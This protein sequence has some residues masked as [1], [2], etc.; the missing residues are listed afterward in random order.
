MDARSA[1]E[2]SSEAAARAIC[3]NSLRRRFCI[4]EE[5]GSLVGLGPYRYV[6]NMCSIWDVCIDVW[7]PHASRN[8][9]NTFNLTLTVVMYVVDFL[10]L[11]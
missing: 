3:P 1:R 7:D 5:T 4:S 9:S 8:I 11:C 2:W 6:S 10:Q